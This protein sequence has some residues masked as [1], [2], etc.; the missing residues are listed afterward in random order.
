MLRKQVEGKS[1]PSI[2][3][4][5]VSGKG[6]TSLD[7]YKGKTV[8]VE[9]WATWCPACR[10]THR[11]LSDFAKDSKDNGIVVLGV[12]NEERKEIAAYA[13]KI[14]PAFTMLRDVGDKLHSELKVNAIPMLLVIDK[15]GIVR[16][17]TIGG[18]S[19]LEE[20]IK[21]AETLAKFP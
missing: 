5:I 10:S 21:K 3:L 1:A 2:R 9:F 13:K 19:D 16:F 4:E 12:S 11:R 15:S 8:L 17:A 14:K 18:G 6:E 20:A 7:G